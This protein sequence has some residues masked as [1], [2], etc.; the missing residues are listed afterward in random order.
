VTTRPRVAASTRRCPDVPHAAW[1]PVAAAGEVGRGPVARRLLGTPVVLYRTTRGD[2]VAL[3]DR[4]AHRPV[5]LSDGRVAGDD[6]YSGYTGFGYGPDGRCVFVPTQPNVPYDVAV[7][8]F[9]V[10]EDGSFVWLWGGD[11]RLAALRR[12]PQASWLRDAAWTTFG[13]RHETAAAIGLLWDNFADITHVAHLDPA[14]SP[15]ALTAGPTPPLTVEVTETTMT[16]SRRYPAARLAPWQAQ[17]L[18][19][20]ETAEHEQLEE[21]AFL[22]PGLWADR[23]SVTVTGHG[24]RDGVHTFVFTHGLT[25]ATE[26][27]TQHLWRV[28]RNFT[29]GAAADGTIRPLMAGYYGRVR[30]VLEQMQRIVDEEG[31]RPEVAVA[32]DAA[33]TQVRRI[34]RRLV[35]DEAGRS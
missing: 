14:I 26:R 13:G 12:P 11:P 6:I 7:R 28:S 2:A 15:P 34:V 8:S 22:A 1:Y 18:E 5:R 17:V 21:G 31:P 33:V 20:P 25:P 24:D 10:H 9:P 23:W 4:C 29:P 27:T 30:E 32:S 3:E 19:L 35:T 16:F